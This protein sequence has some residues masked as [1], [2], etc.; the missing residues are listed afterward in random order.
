MAETV[1]RQ[2]KEPSM[3]PQPVEVCAG[4]HSVGLHHE[5]TVPSFHQ[6]F[7]TL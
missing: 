5:P 7:K 1:I 4:S 3:K 2:V 6:A